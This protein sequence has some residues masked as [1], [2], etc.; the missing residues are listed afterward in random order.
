[1]KIW[2][3]ISSYKEYEKDDKNFNTEQMEILGLK[4]IPEIRIY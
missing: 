3:H 1:M 4:N 2:K